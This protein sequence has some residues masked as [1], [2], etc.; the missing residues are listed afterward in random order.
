MIVLM[1]L[2]VS[3]QADQLLLFS[4]DVLFG[5]KSYIC[6]FSEIWRRLFIGCNFQFLTFLYLLNLVPLFF[7]ETLD[8]DRPSYFFASWFWRMTKWNCWQ[9]SELKYASLKWSVILNCEKVVS[10]FSLCSCRTF[11]EPKLLNAT[12]F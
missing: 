6:A 7:S 9:Y 8:F 2:L 12:K 10:Q 4:C 11:Y 3:F 5:S 1:L